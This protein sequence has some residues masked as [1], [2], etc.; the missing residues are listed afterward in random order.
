MNDVLEILQRIE[1]KIDDMDDMR[2]LTREQL[3]Q[4][5]G[6]HVSTIDKMRRAGMRHA[7]RP[8]QFTRRWYVEF[9]GINSETTLDRSLK[10]IKGKQAS[11]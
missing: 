2:P 5:A 4:W 6:V 7:R 3:A 9:M 1:Q 8:L 10:L 11:A